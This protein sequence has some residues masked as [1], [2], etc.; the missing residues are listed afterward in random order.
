MEKFAIGVSIG[1]ALSGSFHSI[2]HTSEEK[3]QAL[4]EKVKSLGEQKVA[5]KGIK[6]YQAELTR[7]TALIKPG[8]TAS[9]QLK[10]KIDATRVAL[11]N[12]QGA[13]RGLG[14]DTH[15][16]AAEE[17]RLAA[18]LKT[19]NRELKARTALA[20]NKAKRQQ[21]S[22][23]ALQ[24]VGTAYVAVRPVMVA[25]R[26]EQSMAE[27]RAVT[28]AGTNDFQK[29]TAEAKRLG[30]TT[31]FSAS[32]AAAGMKYL[33]MAGFSTTQI[34]S[35]MPGVLNMAR[36]GSVDLGRASDIASDIMS[37]FGIKA[38]EMGRV[39][40]VLT[41]T[42]TSSNTTLEMLGETMKYVGPVAKGAGMD[43]EQAAA[44]AGL[45]GNVGIKG[46]QAGTTLRAM[47]TRL[48]APGGEA[49]KAL[50]SIKLDPLDE[51]G[52]VRDI[53]EILA[54]VAK[55]TEDMGSGERLS[56]LKKI[57]GEE[58]AAGMAELIEQQG[59]AGVEKYVEI[60]KGSKG[61]AAQVAADMNNTA[62]GATRR[63]SSALESL[64]IST[65]TLFLP[66]MARAANGIAALSSSVTKFVEKFP[67][68]TAVLGGA[69]AGIAVAVPAL[70]AVRYVVTLCS[71]VVHGAKLAWGF[72]SAKVRFASIQAKA[73]R[74]AQLGAAAG[75]KVAAAGQW[76]WNRSLAAGSFVLAKGRVLALGAAQKSVALASKI[77]AGAGAY[78]V[79]RHWDTVK[80]FLVTAW[81]TI[82]DGAVRAWEGLKKIFAWSPLGLVM[83]GFGVV[84]NF[85][86]GI[87]L[88][89]SGKALIG[90]FVSGIKSMAAAPIEAVQGVLAKVREYL[91]FSDAKI[92]PL[93][94]LTASGAAFLTTFTE[95]IKAVAMHPVEAVQG[96]LAKVREYLPF[97]DA[98]T[99]PLSTLTTSGAAFV[100]TFAD[101]MDGGTRALA[102]KVSGVAAAAGIAMNPRAA[103]AGDGGLEFP[104]S[105]GA[106]PGFAINYAPE[107]HV[108]GMEGSSQIRQDVEKALGL[109]HDELRQMIADL[110]HDDR[111]LSYA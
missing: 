103:L 82:K 90:T 92:G 38:E 18:D 53:P 31:S 96:V 67:D 59:T 87:D 110:M 95:G 47:L 4:S 43:L 97:S 73:A 66:V 105:R 42:F 45:L 23:Q 57:F 62:L 69:V 99:G 68:E 22:S 32:E 107:I 109:S 104:D 54:D 106:A 74:A 84:K 11:R 41:K 64:S 35:A 30:A 85:L 21:I 79:Y 49:A 80:G 34:I 6:S 88:S 83:Q 15:R 77:L 16:L 27:V 61:A 5:V 12:A 40:D 36:A 81:T 39:S 19:N 52:N 28:G 76:L 94:A 10:K 44:M 3:V 58:P 101:G 51:M 111:R 65:G 91:P 60:L 50:Q 17:K 25:A 46:S 33:G 98:K 7:L 9:G 20:A 8:A 24:A 78:M 26:F 1:A 56:L 108:H 70:M 93:S 63:M 75:A 55:A 72:L 89:A 13:A 37:G 86:S 71:D 102:G 48:A 29:L 2:M 100:T 14:V